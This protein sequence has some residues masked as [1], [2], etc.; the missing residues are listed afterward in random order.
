MSSLLSPGAAELAEL[1][2]LLATAGRVELGESPGRAELAVPSELL[3]SVARALGG[4]AETPE[5]PELVVLVDRSAETVE[6]V[7]LAALVLAEPVETLGL[8]E[9]AV[10]VAA[11]AQAAPLGVVRPRAAAPAR[12]ALT[13]RARSIAQTQMLRLTRA[14]PATSTLHTTAETFH[15]RPT[16]R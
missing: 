8:P 16:R 15:P 4:P 12:R 9:L 1:V 11:L 14:W 5:L 7:E 10:L 13:T 2:E 6:P 3:V